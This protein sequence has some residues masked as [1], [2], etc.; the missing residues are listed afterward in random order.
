[1]NEMDLV[2]NAAKLTAAAMLKK[3]TYL[4]SLSSNKKNKYFISFDMPELL[5]GFVRVKGFFSDNSESE[6]NENFA[7][8][9]TSVSK[10][11][12]LDIMFPSHKIEFLKSLVYKAK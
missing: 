4:V 3:T 2:E 10:E 9:I 8:Y 5:N 12:I 7:E 6:I 1:M 11:L